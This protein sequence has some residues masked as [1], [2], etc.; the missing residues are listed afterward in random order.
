VLA[1]CG[2]SAG[3]GSLEVLH[4][5]ELELVEGEWL[6]LLGASGAGKTTLLRTIAGLVRPS[7]G[8]ILYR[9]KS[10][11]QVPPHER[12]GDGI[13]LVPEGRRLFS[14]MTVRENLI[15]GAF[16]ES[17]RRIVLEQLERVFDLFPILRERAMQVAG[18]LSGGEQQMCAIGRALMSR[19]RLLLVD[20]L[21]LGL[22][23]LIVDRL[24][25]SLQIIRLDG[26]TLIVVEQE[27]ELALNMADRACIIRQG[28]IVSS[29]AARD[30]LRDTHLLRE[31]VG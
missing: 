17:D 3:Y 13:A 25:E 24:M 19:P 21:S 26:T 10:I 15:V 2:I 23:P 7:C 22:A 20:E 14:G 11:V 12:V 27:V 5:L 28:R 29:A 4:A 6:A 8:D 9:G 18:T 31:L 16:L 1:I 30:L